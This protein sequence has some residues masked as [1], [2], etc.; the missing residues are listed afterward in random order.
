MSTLIISLPPAEHG[1]TTSYEYAL[2]PEG[3]T[4][5]DHASVPAAL[6]PVPARGG[7]VVAVVPAARLSWHAVEL[8]KGIGAGSPRLRPV[9]ESLLED[10]LLDEP[11]QLHLALAPDATT[12]GRTWVAACDRQWLRAHLQALEAA[13]R[14]ATRIVPE[15]APETGPL[16][17]H[18]LGGESDLPHLVITGGTTAGVLR[19]PLNAAALT[20]VPATDEDILA[21][22]EPGVA[23]L[24][25]QWLQRP[26]S[27]LT[28]PERWLEASRSPWDLAQFDLASS[29][30]AR[31]LKRLAGLGREWLQAPAWRPARWG[32]ALLVLANLAGLNAWAWKEQSAQQARRAAVQGTLTQT[33]PHV[34]LVVDAPLQMEREVAALRQATGGASGR[35]LEAMLAAL[36]TALPAG[37]SAS[38]IEFVAGEARLKGLQLRAQEASSLSV[39]LKGAGYAARQEGDTV[40]IQQQ[41][42]P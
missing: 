20:L 37:R 18:A 36:G 2:T 27:L 35:D 28:R 21:L 34:R 11:E 13:E 24:A 6:L 25:E 15:F 38:A 29:G 19:I 8:P 16:H 26:V 14:P 1:T 22:A 5:T 10:R 9:L 39:R 23:A 7:E 31:T 12:G 17:L 30:R 41:P 4:L 33:F 40:L 42:T 32:A 3:R